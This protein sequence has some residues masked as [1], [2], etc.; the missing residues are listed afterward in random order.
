MTDTLQQSFDSQQ[1]P[2]GYELVN[3]VAMRDLNPDTIHI[4]PDV[5]KRHI[6]IGHFVELRL[7]SPRFS[8]HEDAPEK[9]S[10]ATCN[11]EM[12]KPI[13]CHEEPA[14]L[15]E[16]PTEKIPARGW[17]EGFWVKVTGRSGN[18][19][20][21]VVDNDL[22]ESRLHG[23]NR[24]DEIFFH[25]DHV[26]ATHDMHRQELVSGMGVTDLKELAAW[27]SSLRDQT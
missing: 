10:C 12:T 25:A 15:V 21:G 22:V 5:I 17:G 4:P 2:N 16:P 23:S 26:L 24:G 18:F 9:C 3:G 14:S 13:V 19:F 1:F 8:V 27:V 20:R 11:G 6:R 7:D